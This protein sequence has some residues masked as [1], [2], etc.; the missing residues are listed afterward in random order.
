[1]KY[2]VSNL[3][4][5]FCIFAATLMATTN[6]YAN[7]P[8]Y[9]P[10]SENIK[11]FFKGTWEGS[12]Q[13]GYAIP[14]SSAQLDSTH[15][16]ALGIYHD[17]GSR[18]ATEFQYMSTSDFDSQTSLGA[19]SSFQSKAFIASL[20]GYGKPGPLDLQYFGRFGVAFFDVDFDNG[21]RVT[22]DFDSGTSFVL[23]FGAEKKTND[24]TTLSVEFTYFHDL[25]QSGYVN[26]ISVGVRQ[27]LVDW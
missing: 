19:N 1:M 10:P 8:H 23:G 21:S 20:R 24:K 4:R 26:S 13:L 14:Q 22:K 16:W 12:F 15:S 18:M 7:D 3:A 6:L 2:S 27:A 25:V 11:N 17:I 5:T 9:T